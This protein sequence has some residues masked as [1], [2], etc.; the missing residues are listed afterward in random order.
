MAEGY[1]TNDQYIESQKITAQ[2]GTNVTIN[3]QYIY[4]IGNVVI[5]NLTVACTATLGN[6]AIL[7]SGLPRPKSSDVPAIGVKNLGGGGRQ[8]MVSAN[9]G[10]LFNNWDEF[11][12]G[13]TYLFNFAYVVA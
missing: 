6:G 2:A 4:R 1:W 3:S 9:T 10:N 7:A 8:A 13:E 11:R 5:V 12:N